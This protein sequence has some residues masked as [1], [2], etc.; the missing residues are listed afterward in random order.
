[1]SG[2][3]RIRTGLAKGSRQ[4]AG[5]VSDANLHPGSRAIAQSFD[6]GLGERLAESEIVD[7]QVKAGASTGEKLSQQPGYLLRLLAIL[8]QE[9]YLNGHPQS[10]VGTCNAGT[11]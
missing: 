6:H 8:F 3:G 4:L 2:R 11:L 7:R 9:R 10:R 5:V 1:G